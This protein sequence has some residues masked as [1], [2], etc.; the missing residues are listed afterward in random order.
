MSNLRT[1]RRNKYSSNMCSIVSFD[2]KMIIKRGIRII[3]A[4]FEDSFGGS[5]F[6]FHQFPLAVR[7]EII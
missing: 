1:E 6:K 4:A 2:G 5:H 3:W 7:Y